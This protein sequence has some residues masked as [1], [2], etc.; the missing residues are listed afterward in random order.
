MRSFRELLEEAVQSDFFPGHCGIRLVSCGEGRAVFR[1]PFRPVLNQ[2][3][4]V[5]QGGAITTLADVAMAWAVLSRTHPQPAF[6][7][8]LKVSFLRPVVGED[9]VCQAHVVKAG[10][11]VAFA[12]AE[13]RNEGGELKAVASGSFFVG[14]V[15][16]PSRS[17]AET[18][19][20]PEDAVRRR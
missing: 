10:R 5:M 14:E 3:L 19:S 16:G 4:G 12:A 17:A 1:L 6:G 15:G 20:G 9:L 11:R 18:G 2:N 7:I 8:D 13:V